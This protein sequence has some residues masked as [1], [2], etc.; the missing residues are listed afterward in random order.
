MHVRCMPITS[1][2]CHYHRDAQMAVKQLLEFPS[3]E[4]QLTEGVSPLAISRCPICNRAFRGN[5]YLKQH[6]KSH[7]GMAMLPLFLRY[8]FCAFFSLIMSFRFN[9]LGG[10]SGQ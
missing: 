3:S 4:A 9:I 6:M 2:S 7:T 10:S 1:P 5:S 8:I